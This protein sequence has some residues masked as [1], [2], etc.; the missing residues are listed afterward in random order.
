[1]TCS[2]TGTF[3]DADLRLAIAEHWLEEAAVMAE[4]ML[5]HRD[6]AGDGA[7]HDISYREMVADPVAATAEL[8]ERFAI[9]FTTEAERAMRDHVAASPQGKH[10]THAYTLQD[11]GLD[12]EQVG[13]R[14]AA[15]LDRFGE[16][17]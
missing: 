13:E 16:L 17:L 2:L 6:R 14:F 9:P 5:A 3:T 11:F 1:V 12:E 15:Y 8:Y 7:F 10:G 4:R